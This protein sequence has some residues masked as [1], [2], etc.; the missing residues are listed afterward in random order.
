MINQN[1]KGNRWLHC[2]LFFDHPFIL[3]SSY[4]LIF[5]S[6]LF[7]V[8]LKSVIFLGGYYS[9]NITLRRTMEISDDTIQVTIYK[10]V[11]IESVKEARI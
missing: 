5:F 9:G 1:K 11:T 7:F 2:F 6:F 3:L 8:F 4:P 10:Q